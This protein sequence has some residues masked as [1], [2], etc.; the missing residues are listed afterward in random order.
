MSQTMFRFFMKSTGFLICGLVAVN[1]AKASVVV[2]GTRIIYPGDIRQ[3]TIQLT[4]H[5]DFP[6]VV[7]VWTD[8]D[9]P[10]S[11]P[12]QEGAPFIVNPPIF[13]MEPGKGQSLRVIYVG[14]DL[15]R[16]RESLF[17]LN[18]QQIPPR[19][20]V[21]A[22]KSQILLMLRSRLKIFYRPQGIEGQPDELKEQ[23]KFLLL[24]HAQ[25]WSV[26]VE[27]PSGY[28]ASFAG[29][30]VSVGDRKWAL[31]TSMIAPRRIAEW[32]PEEKEALPSGPVRL[33]YWLIN[34]YGA[35]L[36]VTHELAP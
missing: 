5:D 1:I 22:G 7:Q 31:Q 9:D 3:K 19:S 15:P 26:H 6:N 25:V 20:S 36:E 10:G 32:E 13:R 34:D 35:K 17:H 18:V 8:V 12:D 30:Q 28:Y 2:T 16:D 27:N 29:A 4:N 21:H 33:T 11:T 24:R 23:L 14:Q